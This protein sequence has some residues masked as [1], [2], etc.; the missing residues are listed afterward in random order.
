MPDTLF[1]RS[2]AP[3]YRN[4][5]TVPDGGVMSYRTITMPAAPLPPFFLGVS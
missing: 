2:P 4:R 1:A 3:G 5:N